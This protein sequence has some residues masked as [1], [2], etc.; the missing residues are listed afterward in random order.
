MLVN[1]AK[2]GNVEEFVQLIE[3][4]KLKLYKT[5][6]AILIEEED[7]NDAI[8]ET[9]ISAYKNREKLKNSKYFTTWIIRILINKCYD[10]MSKNKVYQNKVIKITELQR[11]EN[12][13]YSQIDIATSDLINALDKLDEDLRLVTVLYY[14]DDIK[15]KEISEIMDIPIGTVKSRLS[16]ARERLY[17]I[18]K[19]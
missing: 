6:K 10:I 12:R 16:R 4:N 7:V 2:D 19:E 9:L 11:A 18:L 1:E 14:Y 15:V 3:Q 5:A 17:E 13:H 8:Q